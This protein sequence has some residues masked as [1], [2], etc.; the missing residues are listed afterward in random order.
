MG[1][2]SYTVGRLEETCKQL[3]F[4][5]PADTRSYS[6][7]LQ[8]GAKYAKHSKIKFFLL[9]SGTLAAY[10]DGA[11]MQ[12]I[13]VIDGAKWVRSGSDM[14]MLQCDSDPKHRFSPLEMALR[15]NYGLVDKWSSSAA[16]MTSNAADI[17]E[18]VIN[19][20]RENPR[21]LHRLN[22]EE[23]PDDWRLADDV[24]DWNEH[25]LKLT[26]ALDPNPADDEQKEMESDEKAR[27]AYAAMEAVPAMG[28]PD[29]EMSSSQ[30][31]ALAE[32]GAVTGGGAC[33]MLQNA[34]ERKYR[35]N[36]ILLDKDIV[37]DST[38]EFWGVRDHTGV[39][40]GFDKS[41]WE[42]G[43][44]K[45]PPAEKRLFP[46]AVMDGIMDVFIPNNIFEEDPLGE[47]LLPPE[48]EPRAQPPRFII[49]PLESDFFQN[50]GVFREKV[51]SEKK[52][53]EE[54]EEKRVEEARKKEVV[55]DFGS[56]KYAHF[57]RVPDQPDPKKAAKNRARANLPDDDMSLNIGIMADF[58]QDVSMSGRDWTEI[59]YTLVYGG[60][61]PAKRI[62]LARGYYDA[63]HE[64]SLRDIQRCTLRLT[65]ETFMIKCQDAARKK[66]KLS[67]VQKEKLKT[68][69]GVARKAAPVKIPKK[70]TNAAVVASAVAVAEETGDMKMVEH[71]VGAKKKINPNAALEVS[72]L[73]VC[74]QLLCSSW[75]PVSLL[76]GNAL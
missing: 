12:R 31:Q 40:W 16:G 60:R 11:L 35:L 45:E 69:A 71:L 51:D 46:E 23:P 15:L 36:G 64:K 67:Y 37:P 66:A 9:K 54:Q 39:A 43:A 32:D 44:L 4:L 13:E 3:H 26:Q 41:H 34:V 28:G 21:V 24:T 30:L 75:L 18:T 8:A 29:D 62:L 70:P 63:R 25:L 57:L 5:L 73:F 50:L 17:K 20:V 10:T 53:R 19:L 52:R 1:A 33:G 55:Y 6:L 68:K 59:L 14:V 76:S 2:G 48:N 22:N 72:T 65:C 42:R 61:G 47:P 27:A 56:E 7:P 38:W 58:V 49:N 74:G